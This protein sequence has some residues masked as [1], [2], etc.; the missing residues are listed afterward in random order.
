VDKIK[1]HG[2]KLLFV[3]GF[4][5]TASTQ[6]CLTLAY[7]INPHYLRILASPKSTIFNTELIEFTPCLTTLFSTDLE[8]GALA[9]ALII[10]F[11]ALNTSR[12]LEDVKHVL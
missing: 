6:T 9:V 11:L 10:S 3:N 7:P 4:L 1:R 8:E 2:F 12:D 5:I